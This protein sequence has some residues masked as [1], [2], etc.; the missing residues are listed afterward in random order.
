MKKTKCSTVE[1]DDE[2]DGCNETTSQIDY[3][4]ETFD[5]SEDEENDVIIAGLSLNK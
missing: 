4:N 5:N 3:V 2:D 1:D